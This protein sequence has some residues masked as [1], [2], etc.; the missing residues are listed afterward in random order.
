M[1]RIPFKR[2]RFFAACAGVVGASMLPGYVAAQGMLEE[3]IV[4]AQKRAQNLQ[5]VPISVQ[6]FTGEALAE[7]GIKDVFDLQANAPGLQVNQSQNATTSNFSIR[8]IGTGGNNFGFES[9]VG[10]YVDGVYRAR[11]SSMINQ[12]VDIQSVDILR[13]P[14]GTL[15]G[16]NT[17]SGAI[18]FTTVKPDHDGSGFAEVTVGNYGLLNLSGAVSISAIEDVLAFRVTGFS[19]E[20]D[21]Y[22]E[23]VALPGSDDI[24]D[25]DRYGFRAQALWTPTEDLTVS[26]IADYADLD[27]ICCGSTVLYDNSGVDQRVAQPNANFANRPGSDRYLEGLGGTF[28][29]E[30]KVFDDIQAH[31]VNPESQSEDSGLSVQIDY[32]LDDAYSVTS[33]TAY[34][35]FESF[36]YID[37]DFTDLNALTDTNNAEQE[38]FSQELR[39]SY[40]GE[41]TNFV[42]GASYFQQSLDS[43]SQL[44][45]GV[46]TEF[47]AGLFS[48]L[49]PV[50]GADGNVLPSPQVGGFIFPADGF[51]FDINEQ[52]HES[53]AVFAQA[54]YAFTDTLTLTAGIR[55]SSE[56]KDL[57]ANY[58]E[59]GD[60]I[61]FTL[62]A[63]A[64][65]LKR[66]NVDTKIDD[67][68]VTGTVK[69]SWFMNDDVMLYGSYSTGYKAGGT[70]T[71]R[72]LPAFDQNFDAETSTSY[73][74]GMKAEFPDQGLRLN[75]AIYQA[76]IDDQQVG[77]FSGAG[78][79]VQNAAVADTYGLEVDMLWQATESTT[80]TAAFSRTVA[81]FDDFEKGNCW[82]VT[83]YR[84]GV[85]DPQGRIQND[86]GS[87]RAPATIEESFAPDFC[88]RSGG[89]LADVPE[90]KFILGVRQEFSISDSILG[91]GL[92]EYSYTGDMFLNASNDPLTLQDSYGTVNL[93]LGMV[94]E[95][96]QTEITLWGRNVTD[97]DYL[98]TSFDAVLQSGKQGAYIREPATYGIT[99]NKKF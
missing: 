53:Y 64:A 58:F 80:V 38:Q 9:S 34:R 92:I 40:V 60:E 50:V 69:L 94:L 33:I 86:D 20:R 72:I 62:D 78:F 23:N 65:T 79:N 93:R 35:K 13:G 68:Q 43:R 51:A 54:D 90:D 19:S 18:Q 3:V 49:Y 99:L 85:A 67:S 29:P 7:S 88:D 41:K 73:E 45:F 83:P 52:D 98:A 1:N 70:N 61:G 6:A 84:T 91:F 39:L 36:D 71:D 46:D 63:F 14:Q 47:F 77:S 12:L 76:D 59:S 82:S 42:V 89:R 96:Y 57:I 56:K 55:Y 66:D 11:Q 22:V 97:E 10:L 74:L 95:D 26:V 17:L 44:D 25:R 31:T 15:F 32:D 5:D 27:E 81:D 16:R 24:N 37:A 48:G 75:V 4:T 87:T 30:S 21:G 8:G 2:T 28:I